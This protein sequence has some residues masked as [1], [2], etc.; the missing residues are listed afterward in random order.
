MKILCTFTCN[1]LIWLSSLPSYIKFFFASRHV[2]AIQEKKLYSILKRNKKTIIGLNLNFGAIKT[3]EDFQKNIPLTDYEFYA[4]YLNQIYGGQ[5]NVLTRDTIIKLEP[6]S[7]TTDPN[8][9]IPYTKKLKKEFQQGIAPWLFN[10]YNNYP[11][12]LKGK[13]Y[14]SITPSLPCNDKSSVV[15]IGFEEDSEYFG[16]F[17]KWLFKKIFAAPEELAKIHDINVW[18]HFT[19]LFLLK[20]K[21]LTLISIWNPTFLTLLLDYIK[22]N[23][24]KLIQNIERGGSPDCIDNK[25]VLYKILSKKNKRFRK[26]ARELDK[27]FTK[28]PKNLWEKI[29]PHLTVISCWGDANA[30][31]YFKDLKQY[32]PNVAIQPK[33]LIATEGFISFPIIGKNGCALSIYSHFFEFIEPDSPNVVLP[34]NQIKVGKKYL[35]IITTNGGLYRYRLNDIIKVV[36]YINQCPLIQFC[37]KN[38]LI[39]DMFGEK[40]SA[41]FVLSALNTLF[42]KFNLHPEFFVVAPEY[43]EKLKTYFYCLFLKLRD[44]C[45]NQLYAN[46]SLDLENELQKNF[47]YRYC[48]QLKQLDESKIFV[49]KNNQKQILSIFLEDGCQLGQK[50]GNI[51]PPIISKQLGWSKKLSGYFI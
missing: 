35:V 10:L 16:F 1:I 46:L 28:K 49:I 12:I 40:I 19:A 30:K 4:R 32:F 26:R 27:I 22:K 29:W 51:K 9:Y 8:K 17:K 38:S 36:G 24:K 25:N 44:N 41:G 50:L 5:T 6:T 23:H 18:R 2:R 15:P 3:I 13:S 42:I 43:D 48:R 37:G 39:S 7:G 21:N 34:A 14:W 31:I 45:Q 20:E 11:K 47:H 33:G